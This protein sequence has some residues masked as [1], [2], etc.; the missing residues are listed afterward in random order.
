V[1][2]GRDSKI[3]RRHEAGEENHMRITFEFDT[4]DLQIDAIQLARIM[5]DIQHLAIVIH[6]L[7][8]DKL[9]AGHIVFD[10]YKRKY[11]WL[12]E[13]TD[14]ELGDAELT[15]VG[16]RMESPLF[17]EFKTKKFAE[18]VQKAF[19][20]IFRYVI[21]RLLF[22]DLEREKRSV[23]IQLIREQVLE[24]RIKSAA[25]ALN[26]AKKVPDERLREELIDSLRSS[27]WPFEIEHPPIK[28]VRLIEESD[29][30]QLADLEEELIDKAD[31]DTKPS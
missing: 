19:A 4:D 14:G 12:I 3:D 10:E 8:E 20:R 23:E 15:T 2:L 18:S 6:A 22:V 7:A 13:A 16:L 11:K 28:S 24:K 17:V 27:I 5:L 21:N 30:K 9:N 31:D 1:R 25:S 29:E 26:L